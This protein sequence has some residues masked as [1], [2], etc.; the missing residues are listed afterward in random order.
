MRLAKTV[1]LALSIAVAATTALTAVSQG[2]TLPN[3]CHFTK[4]HGWVCGNPHSEM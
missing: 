2:A 1:L 4:E 3:T